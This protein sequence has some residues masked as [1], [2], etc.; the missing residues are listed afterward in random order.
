MLLSLFLPFFF[1][2]SLI[3]ASSL[4]IQTTS[5]LINGLVDSTVPGVAQFLGIPFAEPPIGARRWLPAL[6]RINSEERI[7]AHTIGL[8]C[9]Q[10]SAAGA[11][12]YSLDVPE[13]TIV[14]NRTSEDCLTLNVWA[15]YSGGNGGKG[16]QGKEKLPVI[17]WIYGG[18]WQTGG[19]DI[20][21]Q[22]PS[23]WV[24]RSGK[25]IVVGIK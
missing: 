9:P 22:I 25:H 6:P 3:T 8:S 7:E 5:G 19:G 13:F 12:V 4:S 17:V 16:W 20:K 21:Y 23:N 2:Y 1:L 11:S 15:P 14:P 24:Q 18:G 10:Y